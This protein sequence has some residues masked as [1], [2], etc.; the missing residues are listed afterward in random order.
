ML[1]SGETS[2]V[3]KVSYLTVES[4]FIWKIENPAELSEVITSKVV[5]IPSVNAE[6]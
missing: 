2:Q 1:R 3:T 5:P 4:K 6:W